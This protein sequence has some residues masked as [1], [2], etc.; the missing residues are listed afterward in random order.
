MRIFI[1]R[2]ITVTLIVSVTFSLIF[3]QAGTC[4]N[5][6]GNLNN[7]K[8]CFI[9]NQNFA[10]RVTL[11]S[12]LVQKGTPT[13]SAILSTIGGNTSLVHGN[14]ALSISDTSVRIGINTPTGYRV[15]ART[16]KIEFQKGNTDSIVLTIDNDTCQV[17]GNFSTWY[18]QPALPGGGGG[19]GWLLT[20][21][22]GTDSTNFIGTIDN[23][24]LF[25]RQN[26]S[27]Y[28]Y[29]SNTNVAIG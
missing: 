15:N 29:L 6:Y 11:Q 14:G 17:I 13:D 16:D 23:Q 20:G 18:F 26:D 28:G 22:L 25:F 27:A 9:Y 24:P 12:I 19:S 2:L 7:T 5:G 8:N 21:N 3:G 4:P 1:V 10:Q